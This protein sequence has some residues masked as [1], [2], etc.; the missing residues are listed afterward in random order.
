MSYR[1]TNCDLC[2]EL[3]HYENEGAITECG[4][5]VCVSCCSDRVEWVHTEEEVFAYL[6]E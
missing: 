6:T 2:D 4:H 3:F 5:E 1:V